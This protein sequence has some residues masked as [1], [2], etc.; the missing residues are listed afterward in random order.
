M[1]STTPWTLTATSKSPNVPITTPSQVRIDN[2]L[3]NDTQSVP[4]DGIVFI[5][6][7]HKKISNWKKSHSKPTSP[8]ESFLKRPGVL[9][10]APWINPDQI[11][12][13]LDAICA[14][15]A[16]TEPWFHFRPFLDDPKDD[17]Y[18]DC[19]L[20]AGASVILSG[21]TTRTVRNCTTSQNVAATCSGYAHK[22]AGQ[23]GYTE[24]GPV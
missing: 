1:A 9:G 2:C 15:G 3:I 17:A 8:D 5:R 4:K 19:A 10:P 16:L 12:T 22:V 7:K 20:A 14:R 18:I 24:L 21:V 23:D 11:D 13:I 6:N